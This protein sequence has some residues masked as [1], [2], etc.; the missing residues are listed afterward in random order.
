[1]NKTN[2]TKKIL[3]A[4]IIGIISVLAVIEI[5][6]FF[7]IIYRYYDVIQNGNV[8][9]QWRH[10]FSFNHLELIENKPEN[11]APASVYKGTEDNS[12]VLLGCS[13]AF[14]AG[15]PQ[16]DKPSSQLAKYLKRTVYNKGICGVGTSSALYILSQDKIKKEI[17]KAKYFIYIFLIDHLRRNVVIMPNHIYNNFSAKYVLDKNNNLKFIKL[18]KLQYFLYSLYTYRLYEE[19]KRFKREENDYALFS[20]IIGKL[21]ETIKTKYPEAELIILFYDD[22]FDN[23]D[24]KNIK[25]NKKLDDICK[26]NKIKLIYTSDL[27]CGKDILNRKYLSY[28]K[29]HP[30]KEAWEHIIPEFTELAGIK[31]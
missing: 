23:S 9:D 6:S 29:I 28:D 16:E 19:G 22:N 31:K 24:T 11:F 7:T 5:I 25:H 10:W 3:I 15:L 2:R 18:N 14:G 4:N 20:A 12:I 30:S 13:Y 21:S 26:K 27:K 8:W 1:M 17:P